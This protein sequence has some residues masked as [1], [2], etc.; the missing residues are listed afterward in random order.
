VRL[1]VLLLALGV[2]L[3]AVAHASCDYAVFAQEKKDEATI[4]QLEHAWSVA[5]LT[6][7]TDFESCLLSP[8]FAEIRSD[9]NLHRLADELALAANH[10]GKPLPNI[11][12]PAG[13]VHLHGDV[14]VAYGISPVKMVDGKPHQS[15]YAD[16]YVWENGAWRVYFAQQTAFTPAQ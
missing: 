1:R 4:Q 15:Y 6:G 2:S 16:Y 12:S 7:D 3:A 13:T 9:G 10:T 11:D 8:D 5:F 14:A